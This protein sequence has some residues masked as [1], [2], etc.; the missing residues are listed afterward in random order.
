MEAMTWKDLYFAGKRE[1]GFVN[2]GN[3]SQ[4]EDEPFRHPNLSMNER[5]ELK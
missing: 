4:I 3:M 5:V 1:C 2:G